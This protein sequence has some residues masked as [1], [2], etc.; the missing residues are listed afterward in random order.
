M[1]KTNFTKVEEILDEGLRK[2][3]VEH[4][5]DLTDKPDGARQK[6]FESSSSRIN[7][8]SMLLKDLKQL[9]KQGKEPY[10]KLGI[11]KNF[12]K[13]FIDHPE[14]ITPEE[15]KTIQG[16]KT[17]LDVFKKELA[18]KHPQVSDDDVIAQQRRRHITKRFNINEKW[19]PLK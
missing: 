13:K 5:L 15:W 18:E 19:V 12:L 16:I 9:Q 1:A 4:L 11:K 14:V 2:I 17:K 7:V 8:V 3:T 6:K 10:E